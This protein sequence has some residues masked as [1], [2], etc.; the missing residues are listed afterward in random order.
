MSDT[1]K[2]YRRVKAGHNERCSML[3]ERCGALALVQLEG[4]EE[5]IWRARGIGLCGDLD[6]PRD[7][8]RTVEDFAYALGLEL[9][10]P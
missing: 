8:H 4:K 2:H 1:V 3:P 9:C 7:R 10:S 6:V 5:W